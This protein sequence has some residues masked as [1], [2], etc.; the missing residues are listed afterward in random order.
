M[1]GP[2]VIGELS[3]LKPQGNGDARKM[4]SAAGKRWRDACS[5][6]WPRRGMVCVNT[7]RAICV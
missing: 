6:K 2:L 5:A 3:H 4:R 7:W 1:M